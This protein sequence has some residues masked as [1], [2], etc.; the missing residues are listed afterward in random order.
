MPLRPDA[1]AGMRLATIY[2]IMVHYQQDRRITE[3]GALPKCPRCGGHRT[4]MI[5]MSADLDTAYLRCAAPA[6]HA[7]A[8]VP[9]PASAPRKPR[10]EPARLDALVRGFAAEF[11][12]LAIEWQRA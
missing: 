12:R 10:E 4:E 2:D 3:T 9:E 5:G 8:A 11:Q 6:M 7:I 1:G